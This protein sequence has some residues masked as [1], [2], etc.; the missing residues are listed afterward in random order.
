[1]NLCEKLC[2]C[3][4]SGAGVP[5]LR[6]ACVLA[7]SPLAPGRALCRARVELW[8]RPIVPRCRY[9]GGEFAW[10]PISCLSCAR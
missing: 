2:V 4:V 7:G 3:G 10:R 6:W 1:M 8:G 5:L 9:A